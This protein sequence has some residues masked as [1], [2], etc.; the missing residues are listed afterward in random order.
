MSASPGMTNFPCASTT[1]ASGGS[2]SVPRG[3]IWLMR[4]PSMTTTASGTGRRVV[5]SMTVAPVMT[6]NRGGCCAC[7]AVTANASANPTRAGKLF[8][9]PLVRYTTAGL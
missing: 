2:V 3:P 1:D 4:V 8:I 5:P 9:I 7:V 6:V